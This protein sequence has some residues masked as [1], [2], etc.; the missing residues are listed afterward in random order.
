MLCQIK[1]HLI[2]AFG[3]AAYLERSPASHGVAA[4]EYA[5][6]FEVVPDDAAK[7]GKKTTEGMFPFLFPGDEPEE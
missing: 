2:G 5:A 6:E 3:G 1:K 4:F 7:Q